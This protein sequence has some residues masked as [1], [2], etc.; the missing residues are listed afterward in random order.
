MS[1]SKTVH[2]QTRVPNKAP[3]KLDPTKHYVIVEEDSPYH[4]RYES[5]LD[6]YLDL[7]SPSDSNQ[8]MYVDLGNDRRFVTSKRQ[9]VL[10]CSKA[11]YETSLA[12]AGQRAQDMGAA[13]RSAGFKEE[14]QKAKNL[15]ELRVEREPDPET[16]F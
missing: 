12:E 8:S 2:A 4:E 11:D 3:L 7:V 1:T 9:R 6:R 10:E 14:K 13:Q 15:S 5:P 16:G